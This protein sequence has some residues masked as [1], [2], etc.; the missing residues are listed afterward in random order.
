MSKTIDMADIAEKIKARGF[1][2]QKTDV[3]DV[4]E[5]IKPVYHTKKL[6]AEQQIICRLF[7]VSLVLIRVSLQLSFKKRLAKVGSI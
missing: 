2:C 5:K 6:F 3:I 4:A 1:G 7:A